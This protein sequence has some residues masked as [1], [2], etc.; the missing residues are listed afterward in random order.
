[1]STINNMPAKRF[2]VH[3]I[4]YFIVLDDVVVDV[5]V[6]ERGPLKAWEFK[7]NDDDV[8]LSLF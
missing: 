8:T 7:I 2:V 5:C 4:H 6:F 3:S 1:M